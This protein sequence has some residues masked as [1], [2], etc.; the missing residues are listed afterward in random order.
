[1]IINGGHKDMERIDWMHRIGSELRAIIMGNSRRSHIVRDLELIKVCNAGDRL[2]IR[3]GK[4]RKKA[5]IFVYG[6]TIFRLD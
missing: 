5:Y 3:N 1:M 2:P 4:Q 6:Y